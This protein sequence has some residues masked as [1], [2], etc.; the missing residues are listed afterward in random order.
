VTRGK[1][2]AKRPA[3]PNRHVVAGRVPK[4]IAV[5]IAS[6]ARKGRITRSKAAHQLIK[7]GLERLQS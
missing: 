6:Y 2:G 4:A 3:T 1:R 7:L 5:A